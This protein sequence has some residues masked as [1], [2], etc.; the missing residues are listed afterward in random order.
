MKFRTFTGLIQVIDGKK[1]F[2]PNHPALWQHRIN[3]CPEGQ[4]VEVDFREIKKI[5]SLSQ[6]NLYWL[7]LNIIEEETGEEV[8]DLHRIFKKKFLPFEVKEKFGEK[9]LKLTSTTELT[10]DQFMEYMAKIERETG[11]P[12]PDVKGYKD[13]RDSAPL[14]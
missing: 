7:Y 8:D 4:A 10:T 13:E 6:N 2:V 5:R 12:I 11:V 9:F 3:K 1:R 14:L